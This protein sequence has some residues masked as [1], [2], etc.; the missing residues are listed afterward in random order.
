MNV[1]H[2]IIINNVLEKERRRANKRLE[3]ARAEI[4]LNGGAVAP[5]KFHKK[6]KSILLYCDSLEDA[7][8]NFKFL[9][10]GK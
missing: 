2:A 8:G 1:E 3:S 5:D 6:F 4:E 10:V 9:C 7:I